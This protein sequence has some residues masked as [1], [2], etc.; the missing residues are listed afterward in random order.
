MTFPPLTPDDPRLT[1]FALDE[2]DPAEH[3]WVARTIATDAGL[4]KQV[5]AARKLH[6]QLAV[7]LQQ[8]STPPLPD[9]RRQAIL[10]SSS[11]SALMAARSATTR[12]AVA[13]TPPANS[14]TLRTNNA[15]PQAPAGQR[16]GW[17]LLVIACSVIVAVGWFTMQNQSP[18]KHDQT[19]LASLEARARQEADA[20]RLAEKSSP[21]GKEDELR[22]RN[23]DALATALHPFDT[24]MDGLYDR[25]GVVAL[26]DLSG[27]PGNDVQLQVLPQI[28][29][30][31]DPNSNLTV[32]EVT[33][34][35]FGK[36]ASGPSP[37]FFG[38]NPAVR[39]SSGAMAGGYRANYWG[40]QPNGAPNSYSIAGQ[41]I[42]G[43]TTV[44]FNDAGLMGGGT[45]VYYSLDG[46]GVPVQNYK[47]SL[48]RV[49]G[50]QTKVETRRLS[51]SLA[52]TVQLA[53]LVENPR[54][55]E[56]GFIRGRGI[57]KFGRNQGWE[58]PASEQYQPIVENTFIKPVGEA[59]LSTFG[60]D[61]DTAS[62]SNMRRFLNH[63]QFPPADAIRLEEL[64]NY[65]HYDYPQ[66]TDGAPFSVNT[67]ATRCPWSPNHVLMRVG[68]QGKNIPQDERPRSNLVFLVDVSGSMS[69]ANKLPLVQQGLKLLTSNL[70]E[71]DRVAIVTYA[72]R[73]Q[74]A[75]PSTQGDLRGQIASVIDGLSSGGGTNGADGIKTAYQLAV[76]NFIEGGSNR[77]ILCTDG[78][79]NIGVSNDDELVEMITKKAKSGVFLSVFGFGMGN[80]KDAKLEKLADKGNGHYGYI[81]SRQEAKKVFVEELAGTLY[82]IAK[83]VKIQV[84]FNPGKVGAYRLL[85]YE[86]RL[87]PARDFN[88]DK[89]DAGEIGAGHRV[90]ALY[91]VIPKEHMPAEINL[92]LKY[93]AAA[94]KKSDATTAEF[95]TVKLRYKQPD[96]DKSV[97]I[98]RPVST[99]DNLILQATQDF[100]FQ[101]SVV[102]FGMLLRNSAHRGNTDFGLIRELA[103]G[104]V[105]NDRYGYRREFYSL[106]LKAERLALKN[107]EAVQETPAAEAKVKASLK[108]KYRN[109]LKTIEVPQ[110]QSAFGN[111][112]EWGHW[113]GNHW[114]QHE[115]L[116][117]GYWVYVYPN[118]Y[119]WGSLNQPAVA[120]K[121]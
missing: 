98:E 69:S 106:V 73:A 86:N 55:R 49:S 83:D 80:I 13:Q 27:K 108:G 102:A 114:A 63:G 17:L 19:R 37:M 76:D 33:R 101:S 2:L 112:S 56:L 103:L 30:G 85:G 57:D 96:A 77:V 111:F 113:T 104:G 28:V 20:V 110:D 67:E 82:T 72:G 44:N 15:G 62:Y 92:S 29:S 39:F 46:R 68:L 109:L 64:V 66:P 74:L 35:K 99:P 21:S 100:D 52:R 6:Q 22:R 95:C 14:P 59:A 11:T 25:P 5:S 8:E 70:T 60:I 42:G 121:N 1:A 18:N 65:F 38:S 118:W 16:G 40:Y 58:E 50:L 48:G 45:R 81:D 90:T 84:E 119:I 9:S 32:S 91:E 93:Q 41:S 78:D 34:S 75:L 87:M 53:L 116:P 23:A 54:A 97:L 71:N 3:E 36:P 43:G 117:A 105:G 26:S 4:Q 31:I 61:V 115:N 51:E 88:D 10:Q 47:S 94:I 24:S 89:K 120:E 107:G 7:S 12:P 79:F